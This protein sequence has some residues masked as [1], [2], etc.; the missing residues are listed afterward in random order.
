MDVMELHFLRPWWFLA[1]LPWLVLLW[2]LARRRLGAGGWER[3]CDSGLLPYVLEQREVGRQRWPL[4]LTGMAGV[5]A[6]TALAGPAWDRL[7]QPVYR[8]QSALV[9]ALDL[10][11]SMDATDLTPSRLERARYKISDVLKSR[12]SGMT[13]LLVYAGEAF[14]VTPLSTDTATI[15]SL[16][17]VLGTDLM[18]AGGSRADRALELGWN[19]LRQAGYG[20]GDILLITDGS[21]LQR[22]RPMAEALH[23][24]GY[25]LSVL[26]VG[27]AEGAPVPTGE[28]SLLKDD[29]GGIV[30]PRLEAE[31]LAALAGAGGGDFQTLR[32]D[33][34]D[35]ERLQEAWSEQPRVEAED[36]QAERWNDRGPWLVLLLIPAAALVFRRGLVLGLL[37]VL[38]PLP[39]PAEAVD[40]QSLWQRA[41]QRGQ[42]ALAAGE[43]V[44]AA[45]LFTDPEWQAVAHYRGQDYEQALQALEPV[46]TARGWYNRGNVL[47]RLGRYPQAIAAYD[48]ALEL[49][50]EMDDARYNRDLL[51]NRLQQQQPQDSPGQNETPPG[52]EDSS[53]DETDS[54]GAGSQTGESAGGNRAGEQNPD[55]AAGGS[56]S[57][58][59]NSGSDPGPPAG[60]GRKQDG[61]PDA[62]AG[63]NMAEPE[64][65]SGEVKQAD[66]TQSDPTPE[67]E[68][69]TSRLT[70]PDSTEDR[71][72][73]GDEQRLQRIPD[74]P[75]GLLRRKF[76]YQ[77]QRRHDNRPASGEP[78]W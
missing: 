27:T 46:D 18:P 41:D 49:E 72:S 25:R 73:A 52:D 29:S 69:E 12:P 10:S 55:S 59:E 1:V 21:D 74:D 44:R 14:T 66:A 19:L 62:A 2:L 45:A 11:R 30:V 17:G 5:I 35:I 75:G 16:L 37:V 8:E 70:Q 20:N 56:Q 4:L 28:G 26:G 51:R 36:R 63:D 78:A 31:S 9:I 38:L 65:E 3:V 22:S 64:S 53:R 68:T 77:Y 23:A 76:E 48:R 40:W 67:Q 15:E 33:N 71:L 57:T 24:D 39:Q 6:I 47:A 7:P 42:E 43:P 61:E 13:A 50:P 58:D 34:R 54:D 32:N 60:T